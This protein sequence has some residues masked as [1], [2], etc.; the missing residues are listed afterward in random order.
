MSGIGKTAAAVGKKI[1]TTASKVGGALGF[2][3]RASRVAEAK[4]LRQSGFAKKSSEHQRSKNPGSPAVIDTRETVKNLRST[5]SRDLQA[6][7]NKKSNHQAK[8]AKADLIDH[9]A[10]AASRELERRGRRNFIV[11]GT[12]VGA[13]AIIAARYNAKR[14]KAAR[15]ADE[16][17]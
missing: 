12:A 7:A 4:N 16:A 11:G 13:G 15:I 2:D 5:P 9:T 6:V 10:D 3:T 17:K 14:D 1:R 8:G